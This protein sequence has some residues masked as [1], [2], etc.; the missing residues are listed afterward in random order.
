MLSEL[1]D[2]ELHPCFPGVT[3]K[4]GLPFTKC[5]RQGGME[6]PW[7]WNMI[8][9]LIFA[10]LD[11]LWKSR[12]FGLSIMSQTYTH[13]A[14]ADNFFILASQRSHVESMVQDLSEVLVEFKLAW[15]PTSLKLLSSGDGALQDFLVNE[16]ENQLVVKE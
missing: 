14:W 5:A 13:L 12:G 10:R 9:K 7:Q 8:V 4:E 16:G 2:L 11:P 6:S 1:C 3:S 15:K